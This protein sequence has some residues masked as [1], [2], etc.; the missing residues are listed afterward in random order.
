MSEAV[1]TVSIAA[2][3]ARVFAYAK[4]GGKWG[5]REC[6]VRRGRPGRARAAPS[7]S[8]ETGRRAGSR[9]AGSP[10]ADKTRRRTRPS[11]RP[12]SQ[13]SQA[14]RAPP[15]QWRHDQGAAEPYP[16][17]AM[18][19]R[20]PPYQGRRQHAATGQPLGLIRRNLGKRQAGCC[21][22]IVA[23]QCAGRVDR[24][25]AIADA[26]LDVLRDD[27]VEVP[28]ERG[29]PAREARAIMRRRQRLDAEVRLQAC[30]LIRRLPPAPERAPARADRIWRRRASAGR[31]RTGG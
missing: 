9:I 27:L 24:H 15:G 19:D 31:R 11:H 13:K 4:G 29:R 2:G 25:E 18:V 3:S 12:G 23:R 6:S 16:P 1:M 26:A 5:R 17:K 20:Q 14:P 28:V 22:C 30:A 8:A 10:Y 21:E 7:P